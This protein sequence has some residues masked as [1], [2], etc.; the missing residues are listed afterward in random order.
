M[1]LK[2]T[3]DSS[4]VSS[5]LHTH[6]LAVFACRITDRTNNSTCDVRD[7]HAACTVGP[8]VEPPAKSGSL[9]STNQLSV[10]AIVIIHK[11]IEDSVTIKT[12]HVGSS[13]EPRS[14]MNCLARKLY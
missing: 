4:N 3:H 8:A 10:C 5:T 7:E 12:A 1:T 14:T 13:I 11:H 9:W 2:D 6:Q